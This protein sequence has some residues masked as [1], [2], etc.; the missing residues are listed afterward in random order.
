MGSARVLWG[1]HRWL[2]LYAFVVGL[3]SSCLPEGTLHHFNSSLRL[4]RGSGS[5]KSISGSLLAPH[6][7]CISA[8]RKSRLAAHI[9]T[10][11]SLSISTFVRNRTGIQSTPD[12]AISKSKAFRGPCCRLSKRPGRKIPTMT[13]PTSTR[14]EDDQQMLIN[15]VTICIFFVLIFSFLF[16]SLFHIFSPQ[17]SP[18]KYLSLSLLCVYAA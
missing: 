14:E 5:A 10:C 9:S 4:C 2:F 7:M 13:T 8:S 6:A 17:T 12:S 15:L 11:A 18:C 1:P 3:D 16:F